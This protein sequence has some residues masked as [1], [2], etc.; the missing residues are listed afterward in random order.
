MFNSRRTSSARNLTF[1]SHSEIKLV[2]VEKE[3]RSSK[4]YTY[5]IKCRHCSGLMVYANAFLFLF[6]FSQ[7][8]CTN[9]ISIQIRIHTSDQ[10]PIV[11]VQ[12][13]II[14]LRRLWC[15]P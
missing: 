12:Y 13:I 7:F 8:L 15:P 1:R 6:L 14:R 2:R 9:W 11:G 10:S 5:N 4:G 3:E